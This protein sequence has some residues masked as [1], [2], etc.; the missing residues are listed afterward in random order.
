M[1]E[2]EDLYSL[3]KALS[4]FWKDYGKS[5]AVNAKHTCVTVEPKF[6]VGN[7]VNPEIA[8]R[9][10]GVYLSQITSDKIVNEEIFINHDGIKFFDEGK[11][12]LEIVN[13]RL[14]DSLKNKVTD[15]IGNELSKRQKKSG[16]TYIESSE[17]ENFTF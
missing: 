10:L 3:E 11:L 6:I 17:K 1:K 16:G 4:A 2:R 9:I 5:I 8:K 15:Q 13:Q 7:R 14:V 12:V